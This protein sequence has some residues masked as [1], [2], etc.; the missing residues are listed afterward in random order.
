M[1]TRYASSPPLIAQSYRLNFCLLL[2]LLANSHM[3]CE[4]SAWGGFPCNNGS[5][6]AQGAEVPASLDLEE[7]LLWKIDGRPG[8]PSPII[9]TDQLFYTGAK[10]TM[11]STH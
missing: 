5:G 6:V 9:S 8:Y 4:T 10:G 1:K 2:A 7:N 11:L 3:Q